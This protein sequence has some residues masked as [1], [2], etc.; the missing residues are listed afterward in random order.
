MA[1][2][3]VLVREKYELFF[4][5]DA[6]SKGFWGKAK[7]DDFNS[8]DYFKVSR[9]GEDDYLLTPTRKNLNKSQKLLVEPYDSNLDKRRS[10]RQGTE[11]SFWLINKEVYLVNDKDVTLEDVIA[12]LGVKANQRKI[13]L[14]KAHALQ[15][16]AS[17][18]E[19]KPR[20]QGIPQAVRIE[21]WQRDYGRC[22]ECES[23]E[24]LEFDHVIPVSMGGSNTARNIQLLCELCNRTKGASL[25]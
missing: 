20:R 5:S 19:S 18:M 12:L 10:G 13:Q 22:V 4:L 21:V 24:K 14:E 17:N 9:I 2:S 15:A 6:G 3:V 25:G 7:V 11:L 1:I 23:Q 8:L 16:M